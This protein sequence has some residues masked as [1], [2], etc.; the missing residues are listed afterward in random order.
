MNIDAAELSADRFGIAGTATPLPGYSDENYRIDAPV[1]PYVLKVTEQGAEHLLLQT[2]VLDAIRAG[3][4]FE[5]PRAVGSESLED[6][7]IARLL[8]WV[9]GTSF[10]DAGRPASSARAIGVA[11]GRIVESLA[12]LDGPPGGEWDL[13][14]A[15]QTLRSRAP[16]LDDPARRDIVLVVADL[17]STVDFASLPRQVI[18]GDL[19]DDNVLLSD[20]E[21]AGI[22][23]AEDAAHTIRIAEPAIAAAYVIQG[24][25]DPLSVAVELVEGFASVVG[26]TFGEAAALWPL[27]KGRLAVSVAMSASG[28]RDNPHRVKSEDLA[29]DILERFHEG[30][31]DLPRAKLS[32][33][34]GHSVPWPPPEA[35]PDR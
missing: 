27:I 6:G 35:P 8:T 11:V 18:H 30:D 25:D 33:A 16:S 21:V 13:V 3:T 10:A 32:S 24:Q 28:P 4:P 2:S 1:G 12:E 15:A 29:W 22:I 20:G 19:N 31:T 23:D 5:T 7:R 17:V 9:E 34:A 26:V 14:N